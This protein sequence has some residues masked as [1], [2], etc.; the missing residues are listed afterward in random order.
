MGW[1]SM[2]LAAC[3]DVQL[4]ARTVFS[5][6]VG[7][8]IAG[9]VALGVGRCWLGD[10]HLV[11]AGLLMHDLICHQSLTSLICK[12]RDPFRGVTSEPERFPHM[13]LNLAVGLAPGV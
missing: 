5:R 1:I 11:F 6:T 2:V 8:C 7:S 9:V 10:L 12:V 3:L 4:L 13:R